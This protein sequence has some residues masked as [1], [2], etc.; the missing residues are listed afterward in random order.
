MRFARKRYE[1]GIAESVK[2][3]PK[4]FWPY[5]NSKTKMRSGIG[6][7]KDENNIMRSSDEDK[8]NILNDFF[9]AVFTREGDS[10]IKDVAPKTLDSL[11]DIDVDIDKVRLE[12]NKI[13]WAWRVPSPYVKE[14]S[15]YSIW[16]YSP[17][18]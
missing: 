1:K 11:H 18:I 8:S 6:D 13:V 5:V 7:L 14:K 2:E 9:A 17:I 10:V 15:R 4:S 16:T 12:P 3:N